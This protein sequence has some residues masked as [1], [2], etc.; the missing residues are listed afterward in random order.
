MS[1]Q[2]GSTANDYGISGTSA[3]DRNA[4]TRIRLLPV[5]K[6][7][8]LVEDAFSKGAKLEGG[9]D[10]ATAITEDGGHGPVLYGELRA[11]GGPLE[12]DTEEEAIALAND[13]EY[14]HDETILPH[15]GMKSS[16]VGRFDA[17]LSE[18]VQTKSIAYR[19]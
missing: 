8:S 10:L 18:W 17:N 5:A 12:V 19:V 15:G 7:K 9:V 4:Y 2:Q 16:G 13:T 14:V 6:T 3:E 11:D 1:H